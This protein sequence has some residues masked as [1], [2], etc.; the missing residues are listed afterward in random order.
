MFNPLARLKAILGE[1][2]LNGQQAVTFG[3]LQADRLEALE[4]AV[5]IM[6]ST[7]GREVDRID[8]R[9]EAAHKAL[10]RTVQQEFVRSATMLQEQLA[11]GGQGAAA[12]EALATPESGRRLRSLAALIV[13]Q[14]VPGLAKCRV[15]PAHD[16]G[17][18][19]LDDWA[20]IAGAL[21]IG[22]GNDDGWDRDLV[23]R[24]IPVAQ[25][26]HTIT[27]PPFAGPGLAW[28]P[29]GIAAEDVNNLRSLRSLI[30]LSGLPQT[31]DLLLK[32]DAESAEWAALGAGETAAPLGRFRQIV[33]EFHWFERIAEDDW[34]AAAE[35]ALTHL[36]R[37]H[38]MVHVHAN[39]WGGVVLLGGI[40][41][42]R[43]LELTFAR[44]DAYAF[45]DETGLFPTAFDAP[46]N[47]NRPDL[48]LGTFR[49]PPPGG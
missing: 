44:R 18:V 48:Y 19:M 1:L 34:F 36:H 46:C 29:L 8:A 3:R 27:A 20:G 28:Q 10:V 6:G 39:N 17:Y 7:M 31:G 41:F 25:Y 26:D 49:F 14:R 11:T 38:A 47:E 4:R 12:F 22:I 37:S 16:G 2:R 35:Q 32:L 33:V 13:P 9:V 45:E 30:S 23:G 24:G 43:V 5:S 42:P 40:A 15:G 21:S